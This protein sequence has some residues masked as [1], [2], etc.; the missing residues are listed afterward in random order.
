MYMDSEGTFVS[1]AMKEYS[2]SLNIEYFYTLGHA[3]VAERQIRTVKDLLYGRIEH[4]GRDWVDV[5]F[6]VLQTD[7]HKMVHAVS[8]FTPVEAT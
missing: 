8:K 5:I 6:E 3:P 4:N 2:E 7:N 1:I